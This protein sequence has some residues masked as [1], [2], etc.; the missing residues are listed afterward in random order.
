MAKAGLDGLTFHGL[1]HGAATSLVGVGVHPRVMAARIGHGT[2]N[3]TM[4]VYARASNSADHEA[5][6]LLQERFAK[7]F[8]QDRQAD[9]GV[10]QT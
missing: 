10:T 2:V 6:I 8:E 4:E 3:T 1:R 7:A 9:P 5:A